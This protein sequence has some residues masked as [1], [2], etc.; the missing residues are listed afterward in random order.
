VLP[1]LT[2]DQSVVRWTLDGRSLLVHSSS[3]VPDPL[4]RV[5]ISTGRRETLRM[6]APPDPACVLSIGPVVVADDLTTY[7][8]SANP[9]R[10]SLFLI[11]GAR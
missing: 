7:A 1:F 5:E 3:Q 4:E 10:S 9:Q 11:E 2:A 8:Y 6:F